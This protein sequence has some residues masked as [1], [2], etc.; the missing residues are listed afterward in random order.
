[1]NNGP[2]TESVKDQNTTN[3]KQ[4]DTAEPA[5]TEGSNEDG[6]TAETL[7][8]DSSETPNHTKAT[9]LEIEILKRQQDQLDKLEQL[10]ILQR[11]KKAKLDEDKDV[12]E[13]S[14]EDTK[15]EGDVGQQDKGE[16]KAVKQC[17]NRVRDETK[18]TGYDVI[19]M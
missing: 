14:N 12:Q 19:K 16:T 17:D 11:N 13:K 8:K 1:M 10:G 2:K 7:P 4:T 18:D 5:K 9:A 15:K 3:Q 6:K